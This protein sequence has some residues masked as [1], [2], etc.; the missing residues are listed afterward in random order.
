LLVARNRFELQAAR[1]FASIGQPWRRPPRA[2]AA[3][4]CM[5]PDPSAAYEETRRRHFSYLVGLVPEYLSRLQWSREQIA[6]EQTRALREL[7]RHAVDHSPWHRARLQLLDLERLTPSALGDLPVMTKDDLMNCWDAIVTDHR[8]TLTGAE[9]HLGALVADAYFLGDLHVIASGGSSGKRGV[10]VYDWHGWGISALGLTRGLASVLVQLGPISGPM[11][12]VAAYVASHATSALAQ[13]FSDPRR[14]AVRAPVTLPLSEIVQILNRAQP[15]LL[16]SYASML[17]ALC[18]EARGGRLRIEPRL[19]LSSSEPLLPEVRALAE[20]TWGVPVLNNWAASESPGGAFCCP[21]GPGFHIGEDV[22]II[23]PIDEHGNPVAHGERSAKILLT[24][25]YNRILP[26]IR[27]EITDEFELA[28]APCACGS[29]YTKVADVHGRADEVFAYA[30][31]VKVHPLNFRTVLG[32]DA[33]I[34]EYQVRQTA[35]GAAVDVV[36]AL[37]VDLAGLRSS[38]EHRLLALG[39]YSPRVTVRRVSALAREATGKL[40]R[41]VPLPGAG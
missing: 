32:K 7:V 16:Q 10:F 13:T 20:A 11:A 35:D 15:S 5:N 38:L 3:V 18:G 8:C 4:G 14:P 6:A 31:G 40:K 23:E 21:I 36:A 24:N 26:L 2:A 25:L 27:Y 22:N 29:A 1:A 9:A 19:V 12:S 33:A 17:P 41:F 37:D 34:V 30:T 28:A 39:L